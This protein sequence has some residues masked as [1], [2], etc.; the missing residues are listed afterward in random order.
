MPLSKFH[1]VLPGLILLFLP[2]AGLV[3]AVHAQSPPSK[4]DSTFS[5]PHR[6]FLARRLA[7]MG[8]NPRGELAVFGGNLFSAMLPRAP[9]PGQ[10]LL[11]AN[12][13]LGPGDVL[14]IYLLG[15]AQ[16]NFEV[17][18]LPEGAVY[19]P[20]TGLVDVAGL[21]LAQART[22]LQQEMSRYFNTREF[23]ATLLQAKTVVVEVAGEVRH[24]GRH[25]LSGLQ[26]V[27]D[28]IELAGGVLP[29]GSLR[30]IRV[31][32]RPGGETRADLYAILLQNEPVASGLLQ[33]GDRI[34]VPPAQRWAAVAGE[35]HRPAI[36]ELRDDGSDSL[37][38]LLQLA[39]GPTAL[40]NLQQVEWSRLEPDGR[41]TTR[42]I[43]LTASGGWRVRHGDRVTL[44]SKLQNVERTQVAIYGEVNSP[45]VYAFEESLRVGDLIK[46]AGGLTRAAYLL[47][48][49]VVRIDP[50]QPPRRENISLAD[51]SLAVH[52]PFLHA[53]DQVFIRRI[54]DWRLGPLVEVRGEVRFPGWYAIAWG[55]TSLAEICS[56]AGGPTPE[57]SLREARLYRRRSSR[58]PTPEEGEFSLPVEMLS[59]LEQEKLKFEFHRQTSTIVSVNFE[60]LL[61]QADARHDVLLEPGDLIEF[62]RASRLVYVT[63]AVGLPGGVPLLA[64]GRVRDYVARAGGFAWNASRHR[65]KVVRATGEVMDDEEA[66]V[67]ASGDTIWVPT[68]G[69]GSTWRTLRDVITVMAQLAT[70]YLVIDRAPGN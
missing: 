48:A 1:A 38:G 16:R 70:I 40:A 17:T 13:R 55:K 27:L 59:A 5:P 22:R 52:D 3:G 30:N 60:K 63:G 53:D 9:A 31:H 50:G 6:D 8:L 36:F 46:H 18:V 49:E 12:Y 69:E 56:R 44:F 34:F 10:I 54:P 47:E 26:T 37:A 25:T 66:G 39:G 41:R 57:A 7:E 51:D 14:G 62:P 15:Q 45:G 2:A 58:P 29:T 21:T 61:R 24:P 64:G 42:M 28:A 11:P 33:A 67:L 35:V 32:N 68:R 43:D 19:I 4:K 23:A 20:T 65:V